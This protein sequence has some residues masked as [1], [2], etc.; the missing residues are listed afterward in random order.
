[1]NECICGNEHISGECA[2]CQEEYCIDCLQDSDVHGD[3]V[4]EICKEYEK[5]MALYYSHYSMRIT[6]PYQATMNLHFHNGKIVN[7]LLPFLMCQARMFHIA[8]AIGHEVMPWIK[9]LQGEEL[10]IAE[11]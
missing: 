9:V 3:Q 5:D 2:V 6:A 7:L 8:L 11:G 4:C 1:M 10:A